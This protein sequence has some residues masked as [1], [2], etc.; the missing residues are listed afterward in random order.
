M[1]HSTHSPIDR[2]H[3]GAWGRFAEQALAYLQSRK[4]EHWTMFLAGVIV[5][6]ILG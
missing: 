4:A 2:D 1:N 6:L 5:G 3:P